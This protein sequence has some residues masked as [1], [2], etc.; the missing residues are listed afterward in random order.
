MS[1]SASTG[2]RA[3][4]ADVGPACD[5]RRAQGRI[6]GASPACRKQERRGQGEA[7]VARLGR[8][9]DCLAEGMPVS[10]GIAS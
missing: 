5:R 6:V 3:R 9:D 8:M 10:A 7:E 1:A 4:M 2:G